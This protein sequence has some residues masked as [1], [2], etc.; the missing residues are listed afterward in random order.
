MTCLRIFVLKNSI[1]S[2]L[3][4]GEKNNN[5]VDSGDNSLLASEC[6]YL[7]A[8]RPVERFENAI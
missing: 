6:Y 4:V 3:L 2:S 8:S 5:G 1:L 7:L